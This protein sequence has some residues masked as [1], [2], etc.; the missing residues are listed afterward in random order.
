MPP[1]YGVNAKLSAKMPVAQRSPLP[2]A[3]AC[4]TPRSFKVFGCILMTPDNKILLVKGR[5]SQKWSFPKGHIEGQETGLACARRELFEETG[6]RIHQEPFAFK[7]FLKSGTS[8]Y[9]LFAVERELRPFPHDLREVEEARWVSLDEMEQLS[10]NVDV[11]LFLRFVKKSLQNPIDMRW[12]DA[13]TPQSLP[14]SA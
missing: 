5:E 12:N 13:S 8:S 4:Y 9:F 11:S 2:K 14:V 3:F 1:R 10:K 7:K 6:I